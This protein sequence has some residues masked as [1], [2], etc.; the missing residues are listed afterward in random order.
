M[1]SSS[2]ETIEQVYELSEAQGKATFI[3]LL[4]VT[5]DRVAELKHLENAIF[6]LHHSKDTGG[7]FDAVATVADFHQAFPEIKHVAVAGG[8]DLDQATSSR[9]KVSLRSPLSVVKFL[10]RT[11]QWHQQNNLWRQSNEFN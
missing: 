10:V 7:N 3:D 4:G 6:G 1:A 11:I 8:I 2:N 9:S 5:N